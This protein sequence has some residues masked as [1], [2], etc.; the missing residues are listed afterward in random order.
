M[1]SDYELRV[2]RSSK[3]RHVF[4][5]KCAMSPCPRE[6]AYVMFTRRGRTVRKTFRVSACVGRCTSQGVFE[7]L[8]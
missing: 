2:T 1:T 6:D 5:R 3:Q 4:N 7:S 8:G